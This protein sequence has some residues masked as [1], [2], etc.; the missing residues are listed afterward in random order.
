[1]SAYPLP[2]FEPGDPIGL[3]IDVAL[4]KVDFYEAV[5]L[6]DHRATNAL[7]YRLLNCGFR[8]PAGAGTDAM[9]NFASL[10]GPVGMNRVFVKSGGAARRSRVPRRAQGRSQH[11]DQRP[12]R[13]A[14]AA[15]SRLERAVERARRR[16]RARCG[17]S[18]A[19]GEGDAALDRAGRQARDRPQ[20]RGRG[21]SRSRATAPRRTRPS[22][23]QPPGP[24][25]YVLRA[26]GDRSRHP[27]LDFY[28]FGTT[29]PVYVSVAGVG[30]RSASTRPTSRPGSTAWRPPPRRTAAEHGRGKQETLALLAARAVYAERATLSTA[31]S[32]RPARRRGARRSR[33]SC[34]AA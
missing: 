24:G 2:G 13:R 9:T 14:R 28:P 5:G 11:G 22:T 16:A 4:G 23:C 27:V 19:R 15:A 12:A 8:L 1:M 32:P 20:R 6:S 18:H 25:W 21:R 29:S 34:R 17:P 26:H 33:G 31:P 3:P 30:A 7:W 10:R